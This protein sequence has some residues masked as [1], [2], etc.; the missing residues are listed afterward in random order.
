ME[1]CVASDCFM[2]IICGSPSTNVFSSRTVFAVFRLSSCADSDLAF[3]QAAAAST[4]Q[5]Q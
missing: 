2:A 4:Q 1:V 5:I 3:L